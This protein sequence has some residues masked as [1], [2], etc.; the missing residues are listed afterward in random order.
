MLDQDDL[1]KEMVEIGIGRFNAQWESAK[2]HDKLSRSKAGQ[3]LIRELLPKYTVQV[4]NLIKIHK[5]KY[6]NHHLLWSLVSFQ[7]Y[8]RQNKL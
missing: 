2:E 8:R 7:I 1:N 4:E 3:R 5:E 6:F